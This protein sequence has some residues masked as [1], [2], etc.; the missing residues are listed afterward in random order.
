MAIQ[1]GWWTESR[2]DSVCPRSGHLGVWPG[3]KRAKDSDAPALRWAAEAR[4]ATSSRSARTATNHPQDMFSTKN[5]KSSHRHYLTPPAS[6]MFPGNII[7]RSG[8]AFHPS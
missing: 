4:L 7:A 6:V 2:C 8:T 1:R 3:D 5:I